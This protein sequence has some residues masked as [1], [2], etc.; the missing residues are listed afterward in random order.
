MDFVIDLQ[1][2]IFSKVED[3]DYD[4]YPVTGVICKDAKAYCEW[5]GKRLS[6]EAEW[7][8]GGRGQK[9]LFFSWGSSLRNCALAIFWDVFRN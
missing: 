8:K 3:P 7:D 5:V 9:A 6:I 1:I 2:I 4:D